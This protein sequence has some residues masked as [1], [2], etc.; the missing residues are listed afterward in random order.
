MSPFFILHG[1]ILSGQ[2]LYLFPNISKIL[3]LQ[4]EFN[5]HYYKD[6]ENWG[7]EKLSYLSKVIELIEHWVETRQYDRLQR[8]SCIVKQILGRHK[9]EANILLLLKSLTWRKFKGLYQDGVTRTIFCLLLKTNK[10]K[11]NEGKRRPFLW[12][13]KELTNKQTQ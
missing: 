12:Y 7:L 5:I 2:T 13:M 1:W 10:N 3:T 8:P 11:E 9:E 4:C 6:E